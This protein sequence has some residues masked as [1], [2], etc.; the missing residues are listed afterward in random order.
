MLQR[1]RMA[2]K[3]M[4]I[5]TGSV[6]WLEIIYRIAHGSSVRD[7]RWKF[8]VMFQ[9]YIQTAVET[10]S[11]TSGNFIARSINERKIQVV[12]DRIQ[13]ENISYIKLINFPIWNLSEL[14]GCKLQLNIKR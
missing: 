7:R 3:R 8:S 14:F 4:F 10:S 5:L 2:V 13:L 6:A 12:S 11:Q 1:K 9:F